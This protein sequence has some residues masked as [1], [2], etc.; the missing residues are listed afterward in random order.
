M[1]FIEGDEIKR[2]INLRPESTKSTGGATTF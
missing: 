2:H 1:Y